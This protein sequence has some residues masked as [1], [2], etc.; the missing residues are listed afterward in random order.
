MEEGVGGGVASGPLPVCYC[1]RGS[2][3]KIIRLA[4]RPILAA[5]Q[6]EEG[7]GEGGTERANPTNQMA[8]D[9]E[10]DAAGG[11]KR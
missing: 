6:M 2:V 4:T 9:L 11:G 7:E 10:A 8:P 3:V 5:A 1:I